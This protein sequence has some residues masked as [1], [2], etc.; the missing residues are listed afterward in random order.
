MIMFPIHLI[1]RNHKFT[2]PCC[3]TAQKIVKLWSCTMKNYSSWSFLQSTVPV[4]YHVA[5]ERVGFSLV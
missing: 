2:R 1:S 4:E 3:Y 5:I